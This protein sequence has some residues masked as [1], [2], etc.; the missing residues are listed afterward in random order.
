MNSKPT[1]IDSGNGIDSLNEFAESIGKYARSSVEGLGRTST[2]LAKVLT[3]RWCYVPIL[4]QIYL[5]V[6]CSLP[7]ILLLSVFVGI[8]TVASLYAISGGVVKSYIGLAI[9]RAILTEMGPTFTG[10]VVASYVGSKITAELGSLRITNQIDAYTVL[11][12]NP[13]GYLLIPRIIGCLVGG[14]IIFIF[15]SFAAIVSSQVFASTV[16]GIAPSQYY[17]SMKLLF[18]AKFVYVGLVKS[19]VFNGAIGVTSCYYGYHTTGGALG[20]GEAT[21]NAVVVGSILVLFFNLVLT[22]ILL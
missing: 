3:N 12:L 21:R 17:N 8:I 5:L 2:W 14:P 22:S 4:E 7:F 18:S 10:L 9:G 20:V 19:T 11:S 1:T 16:L 6:I 15:A 13:E